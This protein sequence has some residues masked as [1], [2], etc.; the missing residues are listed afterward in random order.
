MTIQMNER[1]LTAVSRRISLSAIAIVG[2]IG[3][4][5]CGSSNN[6]DDMPVVVNQVF[7][8]EVVNLTA[9]QP[10]SPI[11][12]IAHGGDYSVFSIGEPAT[13]GLELLAEGG[14]NSDLI[15]EAETA[16]AI[17]TVSGE[18]PVGPGGTETLMITVSEDDLSGLY[19]SSVTMLVNSN[20]AITAA[21]NIGL[22]GMEVGES[23]TLTTISY[24]AGTEA[25]TEISGSIPGPADGGEG[26]N[27]VRDDI[28]DEVRLHAGVIT[29]DDGLSVSR[30]T[31]AH[32]WDNP[33]ARV[34]LT[35]VE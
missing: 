29:S 1:R 30:L 25:N 10:F 35:R 28:V 26:F 21:K 9:G 4:T 19:L 32:R 13:A 34:T 27:A 16:G 17:S 15:Q 7:E 22:E 8:L 11:A 5:S 33:V 31:Q 3:L 24:D 6:D 14:D 23:T 2:V 20:D 18:A 12:A